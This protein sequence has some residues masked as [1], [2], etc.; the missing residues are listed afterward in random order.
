MLILT[1][2]IGQS[3]NIYLEDG[4]CIEIKVLDNQSTPVGRFSRIGIE[5]PRTLNIVRTELLRRGRRRQDEDKGTDELN[6]EL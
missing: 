5:A 4:S 6:S 1:R 3:F 2:F